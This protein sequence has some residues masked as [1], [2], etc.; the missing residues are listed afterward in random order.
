[1]RIRIDG[2]Y[3]EL[4]HAANT[5]RKVLPIGSVSP[6]LPLHERPYTWRVFLNTA[7][8]RDTGRWIA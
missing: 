3:A 4:V 8:K 7:P 6:I 2:T 5:I 1:M